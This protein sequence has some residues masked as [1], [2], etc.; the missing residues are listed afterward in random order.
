MGD[1]LEKLAVLG[2]RG[3]D[4]DVLARARPGREHGEAARPDPPD[5]RHFRHPLQRL[6]HLLGVESRF[7]ASRHRQK[8]GTPPRREHVL[9]LARRDVL[10]RRRGRCGGFLLAVLLGGCR[11]GPGVGRGFRL[12]SHVFPL[13]RQR[14]ECVGL[15]NDAG[16]SPWRQNRSSAFGSNIKPLPRAF[17]T[18]STPASGT[19]TT[20]IPVFWSLLN[21]REPGACC[22][23]LFTASSVVSIGTAALRGATMNCLGASNAFSG[24][25]EAAPIWA[26]APHS[27]KKNAN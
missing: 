18:W 26:S 11:L 3:G 15:R 23:A 4:D 27:S 21:T 20:T 17:R 19:S 14:G 6:Q 24:S 9:Q 16:R 8:I 12:I 13:L 2:R 5:D 10:L 22:N 7:D 1:P 25:L